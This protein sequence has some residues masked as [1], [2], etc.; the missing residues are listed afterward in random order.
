MEKH[1]FWGLLVSMLVLSACQ[2]TSNRPATETKATADQ[3]SPV[4]LVPGDLRIPVPLEP[5]MADHMKQ[6]MR[7]HLEALQGITSS[8]AVEDWDGVLAS[9]KLLGSGSDG[10]KM[11]RRMGEGAPGFFEM[12]V[13]LHTQADGIIAAAKAQDAQAVLQATGKTMA[14]CTACHAAYRQEILSSKQTDSI[15]VA[16]SMPS[17]SL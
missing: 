5:M 3:P 16:Q 1:M 14:T 17:G 10:R 13:N 4:R 15:R 9:A 8:L 11:C 2:T 12:G 7:G 6:L